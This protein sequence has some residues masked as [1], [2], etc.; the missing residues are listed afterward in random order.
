MGGPHRA[1]AAAPEAGRTGRGPE[2]VHLS[3]LAVAERPRPGAP[4][5]L[6][7]AARGEPDYPTAL[8]DLRDAPERVWLRGAAVPP[9]ER[10]VAVVGSRAASTP[11]RTAVRSRAGAA[12]LPSCRRDSTT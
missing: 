6:R 4:A 12:P 5:P 1:A 10:C 11:P 2:A 7:A 3:A 8:L 9:H